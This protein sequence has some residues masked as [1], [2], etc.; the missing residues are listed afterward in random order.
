MAQR[1]RFR[2]GSPR[3]ED[4]GCLLPICTPRSLNGS[5]S[6]PYASGDSPL[7][8][9]CSRWRRRWG[10]RETPETALRVGSAIPL[11][12]LSA[13]DGHATSAAVLVEP[14]RLRL[15]DHPTRSDVEHEPR[16]RRF[17]QDDRL[18]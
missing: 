9:R 10:A 1:L 3:D 14:D 11:P 8:K 6:L 4:E 7:P 18:L 12:R 5:A 17:H 2:R 13:D 16:G 15:N